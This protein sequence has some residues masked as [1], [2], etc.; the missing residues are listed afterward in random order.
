MFVAYAFSVVVVDG[1][2]P[3]PFVQC[4]SSDAYHLWLLP[5]AAVGEVNHTPS[6]KTANQ[7]S[8]MIVMGFMKSAI[9]NNPIS[10]SRHLNIILCCG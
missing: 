9:V 2:M 3:R 7:N 4:W 1:N 8:R 5:R 6:E 10:V